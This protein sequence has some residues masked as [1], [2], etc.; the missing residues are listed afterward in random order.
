MHKYYQLFLTTPFELVSVMH[1]VVL[2]SALV[3]CAAG[4]C[5]KH[6]HGELSTRCRVESFLRNYQVLSKLRTSPHF[7]VRKFITAFTRAHHLSQ[8]STRSI[9]HMSPSDFLTIP[10]NIIHPA[11]RKSL[12]WSLYSRVPI[13]IAYEPLR[14]LIR[15]TCS[16]R[17]I[18]RD[19]INRSTFDKKYRS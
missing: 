11:M 10:F 18:L 2:L 19:L 8:S 12:Q 17:L 14:S 4:K 16:K 7:M 15:A 5:Y 1:C 6:K 13:K 3:A 9:Q